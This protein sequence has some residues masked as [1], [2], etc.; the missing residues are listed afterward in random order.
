MSS[1]NRPDAV[2]ERLVVRG[3]KSHREKARDLTSFATSM[4]NSTSRQGH[5]YRYLLSVVEQQQLEDHPRDGVELPFDSLATMSLLRHETLSLQ[6]RF[7]I[8]AISAAICALKRAGNPSC[9]L[10]AWVF[11]ACWSVHLRQMISSASVSNLAHTDLLKKPLL[12]IVLQYLQW[13]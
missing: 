9:W 7:Q 4:L 13:Q 12:L 11:R 8:S 6:F 5:H 10:V 3:N 2:S 1:L